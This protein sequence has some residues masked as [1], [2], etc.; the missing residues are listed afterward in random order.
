MASTPL[1]HRW[2]SGVEASL[3]D[4]WNFI[5]VHVPSCCI[6]PIEAFEER[7]IK[8]PRSGIFIDLSGFYDNAKLYM[9]VRRSK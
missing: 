2:L 7:S 6:Q 5:F 1:S 3:T 9:F 4:G 8:M